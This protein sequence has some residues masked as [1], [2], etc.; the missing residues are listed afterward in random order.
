[1]L[2][3]RRLIDVATAAQL[4]ILPGK[5]T[6]HMAYI[7]QEVLHAMTAFGCTV[8]VLYVQYWRSDLF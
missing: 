7:Q 8:P 2:N 6:V 1:M 4:S 3:D 5:H